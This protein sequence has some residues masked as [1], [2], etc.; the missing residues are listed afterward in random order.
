MT[1]EKQLF[2]SQN[3]RGKFEPFIPEF[4]YLLTNGSPIIFLQDFGHCGPDGPT[5]LLEQLAP[6]TVLVNANPDKKSRNTGLIIHKD[7]EKAGE[8]KKHKWA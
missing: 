1:S 6:H 4:N 5:D 3:L 8:V 2:F 7:W